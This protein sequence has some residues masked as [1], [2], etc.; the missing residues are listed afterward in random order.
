M[1]LAVSAAASAAQAQTPSFELDG[2]LLLDYAEQDVRS[3]DP[4]VDSETVVDRYVRGARLRVD[5]E[6]T[7]RL[8]FRVE[9]DVR[10]G[11]PQVNFTDAY[12]AYQ[13]TDEVTLRLGNFRTFS[14][15][16]LTSLND[17]TFMNRGAYSDFVQADRTTAAEAV[18]T[19]GPWRLS[20]AAISDSI[21]EA[22]DDA[23]SRGWVARA[24]FAPDIEGA[25]SLHLAVWARGRES[26]PLTYRY[27]VRSNAN[28]GDRLTDAGRFES[29]RTLGLE[30]AVLRGPVTVQAEYARVA[31][32]PVG[33]GGD[34]K[35]VGWYLSASWFP[36]GDRRVYED[37]EIDGV[38]VLRPVTDGGFGA[39]E[40]AIRRDA[41]DLSDLPPSPRPRAGRYE[42]WTVGATWWLTGYTRL[43][44][45]YTDA[46]NAAPGGL[47]EADT[48][49]VRAQYSF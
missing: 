43:M 37:G 40:L 29:D 22:D 38:E 24:V 48:F 35:G 44:A 33:G 5:G 36:T 41:V 26:G 18:F 28:I 1:I 6:L 8:S 15:E 16:A 49:Q 34:G 20:A 23:D 46:N 4:A 10:D 21:N 30:A 42:A 14:I 47:V 25:D 39:V 11:G 2:R 31:V 13:A 27:G 3:A 7:E 9:A 19:R 32:E 45:N 12:L 17:I